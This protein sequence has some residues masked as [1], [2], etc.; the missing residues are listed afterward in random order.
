MAI[1]EQASRDA[2]SEGSVLV[3]SVNQ[4]GRPAAS[5]I[6]PP[7]PLAAAALMPPPPPLPPPTPPPPL[8]A[9]RGEIRADRALW[10]APLFRFARPLRPP[11]CGGWR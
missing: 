4:D 11:A 6:A 9:E 1:N 2:T 7:P 5:P 10:R 3:Y 8:T